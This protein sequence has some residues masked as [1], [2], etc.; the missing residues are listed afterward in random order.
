MAVAILPSVD[1][2]FRLCHWL[3]WFGTHVHFGTTFKGKKL[4]CSW[5]TVNFKLIGIIY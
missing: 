2:M 3:G 5:L 1:A 4:E